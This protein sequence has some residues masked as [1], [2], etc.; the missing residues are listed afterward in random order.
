[1]CLPYEGMSGAYAAR[2]E[3]A[4]SMV[5]Y[6]FIAEMALKLAGLGCAAYWA[7]GW[8]TLDGTIVTISIVEIV[9]TAFAAGSGIKLSFLRMLRMLRVLR[10]L[11]LMRTWRGLYRILHTFVRALPHMSN[12]VSPSA[13]ALTHAHGPHTRPRLTH[14]PTAHLPL[15]SPTSRPAAVSPCV[16]PSLATCHVPHLSPHV[17]PFLATCAS[18][19]QHASLAA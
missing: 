13:S 10:I 14:T 4:A 2:L 6:I 16:P 19:P 3:S 5:T 15:P 7:D 8:N 11:R 9:L 18:V 12:L 1:M 17:P